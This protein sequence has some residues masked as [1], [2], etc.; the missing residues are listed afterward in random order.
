MCTLVWFMGYM[1]KLK[2]FY[3]SKLRNIKF[4]LREFRVNSFN[5]FDQF[6]ECFYR[7][8]KCVD[9]LNFTMCSFQK[10]NSIF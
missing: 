9:M 1:P 5:F 10:N 6:K 7:Y 4:L 2:R 3:V 8:F